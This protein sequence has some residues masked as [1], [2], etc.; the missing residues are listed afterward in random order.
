[1]RWNA[2]RALSISDCLESSMDAEH[3]TAEVLK[4]VLHYSPETGLF[5]WIKRMGKRGMPGRVAGTVDFSGYV[6]VTI[7]KKR[8]KAHRLAWLYTTGHWPV[9]AMDHING[10]RADNRLC[11]LRP[12][13]W[14]ENQQNRGRQ[15][16]NRSGFTGVSWDRRAGN[17]RAGIRKGGQSFNLG[18]H[19]T[20][21]AASLAYR[22]AKAAMHT[23]Q[24]APRDA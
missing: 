15:R 21:E 11:N 14:A 23:F 6:V 17:W 4:N 10:D 3:L 8:H 16:N 1:M 9:V 7:N 12:A 18:G 24:P 20:P 5:T 22:A 19:G 2:G 13:D